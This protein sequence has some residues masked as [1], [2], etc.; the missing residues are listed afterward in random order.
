MHPSFV[1]SRLPTTATSMLLRVKAR[2]RA[3]PTAP[4]PMTPQPNWLC[5]LIGVLLKSWNE[6]G[7]LDTSKQLIKYC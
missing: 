6:F 5:R 3:W 1:G 7:P 2:A 4:K